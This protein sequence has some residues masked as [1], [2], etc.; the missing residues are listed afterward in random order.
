MV[1]IEKRDDST[2]SVEHHD[3][4]LIIGSI[5]GF[6]VMVGIATCYWC[7]EYFHQSSNQ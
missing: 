1:I 7:G 6:A 3:Y 5:V 2:E 4:T